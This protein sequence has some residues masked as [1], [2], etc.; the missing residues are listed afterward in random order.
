M[1]APSRGVRFSLNVF[2]LPLQSYAPLAIAAERSGYESLWL[3][4]HLIAPVDWEPTY[5]YDSTGRPGAYGIDTP[6]CDVWVTLGHLACA[7]SRITLA[8]GVYILPLRNPFVTAKAAA[9]VQAL[10]GG[11]LVLGVGSGWMREEFDAVGESF[12]SRGARMDEIV[13]ILR[14]LW[15]GGPVS[16]RGE[17][18]SFDAVQMNPAAEPAPPIVV[19]GLT[20]PALRR[21]ARVGDGWFGP[22]ASLADAVRARD[23]IEAERRTLGRDHLPFR[24][25]IRIGDPW[26]EAEAASIAA[27]GF[28]D[29]VVHPGQLVSNG[30][31]GQ[32]AM[33]EGIEKLAA[34]A[35]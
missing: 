4:D 32:A 2:G 5:P 14:K 30:V 9:T 12:D 27:A 25:W 18:Y 34:V 31:R 24:Y 20:P 13:A 7:T 11:R 23:T 22:A 15:T 21:A 28:E 16:H 17:H 26:S 8:T 29:V 35:L 10:S 19:G 33:L 1:S 6:L 3:S